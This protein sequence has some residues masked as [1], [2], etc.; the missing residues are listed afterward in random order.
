[1]ETKHRE[2]R[3]LGRLQDDGVATRERRAELPARDVEREVPRHDQPDDAE[4]LA[5]RHVDAARDGNR[6]TVVLLD[7]ARVEVED[8]RHHRDLRARSTDRLAY[9]LRLDARE[10][11]GMLVHERR[12]PAQKPRAIERR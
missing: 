3:Q 7:R 2:R 9:V 12:Y 5:E 8:V 11:F 10:L 6:L 4:R 1:G